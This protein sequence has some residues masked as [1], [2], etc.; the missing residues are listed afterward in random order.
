MKKSISI[1]VYGKEEKNL[2]ESLVGFLTS[3]SK[4]KLSENII[5]YGTEA[6]DENT[7]GQIYLQH[8]DAEPEVDYV[9]ETGREGNW[10]YQIWRSGFVNCWGTVKVTATVASAFDKDFLYCN[11][12]S[13]AQSKYPELFKFKEPPDEIATLK[14]PSGTLAWLAS[15]SSNTKEKT[16][17][18]TII[19]PEKQTAKSYEIVLDVKGFID[20]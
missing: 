11:D 20:N 7:V 13:I 4:N 1:E 9:V 19:S 17:K 5:T 18:Y 2:L 6:P 8:Y 12:T 10:M 15:S 16:G 14:S 3:S